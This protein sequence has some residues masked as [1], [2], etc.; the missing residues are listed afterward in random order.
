MSLYPE[1]INVRHIARLDS[2]TDVMVIVATC[3]AEDCN[4]DDDVSAEVFLL[5]AGADSRVF[6]YQWTCP[7][8]GLEVVEEREERDGD[9]S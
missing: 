1:G 9:D 7:G 8:C 2:N 5:V 3:R 6:E 4:F